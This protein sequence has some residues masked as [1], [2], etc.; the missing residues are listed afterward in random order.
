[1]VAS[2]NF[3]LV[4]LSQ[5]VVAVATPRSTKAMLPIIVDIPQIDEVREVA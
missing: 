5:G 4:R 1:M 3:R 2:G